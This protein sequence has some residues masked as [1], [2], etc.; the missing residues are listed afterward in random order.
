MP[1]EISGRIFMIL[2]SQTGQGQNG[3]WVKQQFVIETNTDRYPKKICFVAW[4]DRTEIISRMKPGD[5][6]KV[7]F[8]LESREFNGR[9]YTDAKAW[10]IDPS[11][12]S[13]TQPQ[14]SSSLADDLPP[15]PPDDLPF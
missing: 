2:P 4:N 12:A 8:D 11:S 15:P 7:S 3:N 10:R 5:E 9:W 13:S 6:V 1:N 14:T